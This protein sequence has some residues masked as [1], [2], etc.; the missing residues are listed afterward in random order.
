MAQLV[1]MPLTEPSPAGDPRETSA[2]VARIKRSSRL[3][4]EDKTA[5]GRPASGI[6][7]VPEP[8]E[9][10]GCAQGVKAGAGT[11]HRE[12]QRSV[13]PCPN[14]ERLVPP[15]WLGSAWRS[16][17]VLRSRPG[18]HGYRL[19]DQF[20][21]QRT[22]DTTTPQGQ[23]RGMRTKDRIVWPTPIGLRMPMASF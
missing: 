16:I 11:Q 4:R 8:A 2:K 22:G 6:G 14:R 9:P 23:L 19:V 13:A 1:R 7:D 3:R 12:A 21:R 15:H 20:P 17:R 18:E 10:D 5:I